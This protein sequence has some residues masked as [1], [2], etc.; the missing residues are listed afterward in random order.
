MSSPVLQLV[1]VSQTFTSNG[2]PIRA[3]DGV[4]LSI[5]EGQTICLVGE[6]GCGKTTTGKIAAG[7]RRPTAGQVL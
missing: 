5:D 6:S 1:D 4:S 2:K 7:L 3:L